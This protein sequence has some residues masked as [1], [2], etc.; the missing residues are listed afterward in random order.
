MDYSRTILGRNFSHDPDSRSGPIVG[1][2]STVFLVEAKQAR[3]LVIPVIISDQGSELGIPRWFTSRA[4]PHGIKE[5]LK[6][7]ARRPCPDTPGSPIIHTERL[8]TL[9]K[10]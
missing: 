10:E 4:N 2:F 1:D 9:G 6:T 3:G 8:A 5:L 7:A